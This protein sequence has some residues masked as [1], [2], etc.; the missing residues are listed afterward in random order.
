MR[1]H[2]RF[3]R[4]GEIGQKMLKSGGWRL[5]RDDDDSVWAIHPQ[6]GDEPSARRYLHGAG[7][8]T[9]SS[10]SIEFI[11]RATSKHN[12]RPGSPL[13][14]EFARSHVTSLPV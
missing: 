10:V 1:V 12:L 13:M 5:V 7:L 4:N 14:A 9:A 11:K 6:V 2:L 3:L 8:L